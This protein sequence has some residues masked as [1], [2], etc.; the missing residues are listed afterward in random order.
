MRII[1]SLRRVGRGPKLETICS[2]L[3]RPVATDTRDSWYIAIRGA[4]VRA[5]ILLTTN[6]IIR[7]ANGLR[8]RSFNSFKLYEFSKNTARSPIRYAASG[9]TFRNGWTM[10]GRRTNVGI[11]GELSLIISYHSCLLFHRCDS[12]S[13]TATKRPR[14]RDADSKKLVQRSVSAPFSL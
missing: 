2:V 13:P 14:W 11:S 7:Q 12:L 10:F 9:R 6:L 1:G 4:R 5:T 3:P 8:T